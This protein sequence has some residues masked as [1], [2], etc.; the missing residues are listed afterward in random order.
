MGR[1]SKKDRSRKANRAGVARPPR[2]RGLP[3]F[4]IVL[5]AL[6]AWSG[7]ALWQGR[8]TAAGFSRYLAEGQGLELAVEE[9]PALGSAH[10]QP[11]ARFRYGEPTP[12]SGPHSPYDL[13][14]G[15]YTKPQSVERLV[16]NL[17][18]GNVVVYYDAADPGTLKLLK[19]WSRTFGGPM[20]GIVVAPMEGLGR[21]VV[22]TAWQKKLV[23]EPFDP[24]AA[25]VFID[26]YRGRGP[27]AKVR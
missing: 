10:L 23:L 6:V 26:A 12:T 24:A 8:A 11:G 20:D 14:P 19:A 9:Q 4:P 21:K 15:F 2:R 18:H 16:H 3:W 17:E 27:E 22:L 25:A 13:P 1:K 7:Y 5:A